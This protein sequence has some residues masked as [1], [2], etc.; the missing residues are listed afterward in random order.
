MQRRLGASAGGE[1]PSGGGRRGPMAAGGGGRWRRAAGADG[2]GQRGPMAAGRRRERSRGLAG[3][4]R[5][6]GATR[7]LVRSPV[8]GV[9]M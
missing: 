8:V 3:G 6:A 4:E 9:E 5:V 7:C 2:G 1:C